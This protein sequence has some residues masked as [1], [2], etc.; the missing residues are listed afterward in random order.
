M[1]SPWRFIAD[2]ESESETSDDGYGGADK[3]TVQL[4]AL[5]G[6]VVPALPSLKDETLQRCVIHGVRH[7]ADYASSPEI[8]EICASRQYPAI[9]RARH[10]RL[11]MSDVIPQ[12]MGDGNGADQQTLPYCIWYP[13]VAREETYRALVRQY[14]QM[15]YAVGRACAVA[16]YAALY[17]ELGLLPDVS[18]A[19][20]ARDNMERVPGSRAI[21][22]D[23]MGQTLRF[24][25]MDDYTR[26]VHL[27]QPR[28]GALLNDDTAVR[29][30]LDSDSI[31][32]ADYRR[33]GRR[34]VYFDIAEDHGLAEETRSPH[35]SPL[36][37]DEGTLA[38]LYAP[39]PPDL[40]AVNKDMLILMAAAEGNVD[41]YARLRRPSLVENELFCVVRGIY[42]STMFAKWWA[43]QLDDTRDGARAPSPVLE[44]LQTNNAPFLREAVNARHIMSNDVSRITA[45]TPSSEIPYVIWHPRLPDWATLRELVRRRPDMRSQAAHACIVADYQGTYDGLQPEPSYVL[46]TEAKRQMHRNPHYAQDL[47]QRA[48]ALGL[49]LHE[50]RPA[51]H[52]E[53]V[54][55]IRVRDTDPTDAWLYT[56][57]D[58]SLMLFAGHGS[59]GIYQGFQ[60]TTSYVDLAVCGIVEDEVDDDVKE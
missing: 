39:L 14:P 8:L 51:D 50:E 26:S 56:Q 36:I 9:V 44:A 55:A 52:V 60:P 12:D 7:H 41:R 22:R 59:G 57:L 20:E 1:P 48:D 58:P 17:H 16:G 6:E 10:A 2:T 47:E 30:R 32:L 37:A 46:W 49:S 19:D 33:N 24:A 35:W 43:M 29:S 34:H 15:R 5:R 27:E 13:D 3:E 54:G 31:G 42:H 18:I 4:Q 11:I 23:I 25:V 40:Q 38:L 21:F 45:E 28:A 53:A